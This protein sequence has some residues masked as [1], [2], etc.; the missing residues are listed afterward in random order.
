[1]GAAEL[2]SREVTELYDLFP[3]EFGERVA[4]R[5]E[6]TEMMGEVVCLVPLQPALQGC[7]FL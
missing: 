6:V 2:P 3:A 7:F 4:T 1:M 5:L